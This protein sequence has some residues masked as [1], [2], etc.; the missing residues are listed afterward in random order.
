MSLR[1]GV[2]E[3]SRP[4]ARCGQPF[5]GR[6]HL[7]VLLCGAG[8]TSRGSR[9]PGGTGSTAAPVPTSHLRL[10]RAGV[11]ARGKGKGA[12]A[13]TGRFLCPAPSQPPLASVRQQL[14]AAI[15]S[16]P[17]VALT[18][19]QLTEPSLCPA[20]SRS[21]HRGHRGTQAG[22]Q[23]RHHSVPFSQS[24][25]KLFLIT[26]TSTQ[27]SNL[28]Q[29]C[30]TAGVTA[31]LRYW[32]IWETDP[33]QPSPSAGSAFPAVGGQQPLP[34]DRSHSSHLCLPGGFSQQ[35]TVLSMPRIT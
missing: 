14:W 6:L 17:F 27:T 29:S 25:A 3:R 21:Q 24:S 5:L 28:F 19:F 9:A 11:K 2:W 16:D 12:A 1:R 13:G 23:H 4:T 7:P 26:Q 18:H 34:Q 10:C 32:P 15:C 31:F 20:L 8:S 35:G 30:S 33:E 22:T